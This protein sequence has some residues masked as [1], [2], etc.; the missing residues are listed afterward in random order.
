MYIVEV[1][2][3]ANKTVNAIFRDI[4]RIHVQG[5]EARHSV[6][7]FI[8]VKNAIKFWGLAISESK[9]LDIS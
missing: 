3:I 8:T 5:L 6:I 9:V 1:L 2:V 4:V 7:V